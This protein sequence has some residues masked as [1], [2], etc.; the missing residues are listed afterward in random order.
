MKKS[1]CSSVT[2]CLQLPAR[3]RYL[4]EIHWYPSQCYKRFFRSKSHIWV[5]LQEPRQHFAVFF[6][7]LL[8]FW[9]CRYYCIV[10]LS[11]KVSSL[12]LTIVKCNK[13]NHVYTWKVI[14]MKTAVFI[15]SWLLL[16]NSSCRQLS[17][18]NILS[19]ADFYLGRLLNSEI[20]ISAATV[21]GELE[22][23]LILLKK[24]IKFNT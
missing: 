18:Q 1:C 10:I 13:V 9:A 15:L 17:F 2:I 20:N 8:D 6:L 19:R 23:K 21:S 12:I 11:W 4:M 16:N 7:H 24:C 3:L 5:I 22:D 14:Q